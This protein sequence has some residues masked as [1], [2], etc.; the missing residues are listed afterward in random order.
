MY[1]R[2]EKLPMAGPM[3]PLSWRSLLLLF[4]WPAGILVG[5]ATAAAP[6]SALSVG[7]NESLDYYPLF[8]SW[9][10]A[11]EV[12]RDGDKVLAPYAVVERTAEVAVVRNGDERIAYAILPDG[13]ARRENGS[14]GDFLVRSPLR[15]GSSWPL[16]AGQAKVVDTG[17]T[18][19]LPSGTYR[20]C[21]VVEE[22]RRDPERVTRT[23]YCRGTGP[24]EME[25]RVF[26]PRTKALEPFAHARI[27][28]VTR[29]E[30]AMER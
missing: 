16:G 3:G 2:A 7:G 10:W 19:T 26:D 5:C 15:K 22:T 11:F 30:P 24:V 23:S 6:S 27:L 20:D 29:P 1:I 4:A 9:G 8:P 18:I 12:E 17:L 25:M 21:A 28:A 13:I 14:T